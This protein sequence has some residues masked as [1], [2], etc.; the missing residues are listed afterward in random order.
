MFTSGAAGSLFFARKPVSQEEAIRYYE[1][2]I[3][4]ARQLD[5]PVLSDLGTMLN[6]VALIF[7]NQA[8]RKRRSRT[9]HALQIYEKQ[10][11][12]QHADV[13]SVLNN[14]AVFLHQREAYA[15]AEKTH[16]RALELEKVLPPTIP[17]RSIK[18]QPGR[19]LSF[20]RRLSESSR[21]LSGVAQELEEATDKPPEA[22]NRRCNYA[23]LLRS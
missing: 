8:G 4:A 18:M 12:P 16:L 22:R 6:N 11:G 23:D 20:P 13:A 19:G 21:A 1:K 17:H 15:E 5:E 10:I 7:R 9:T 14:L 3:A 2:A